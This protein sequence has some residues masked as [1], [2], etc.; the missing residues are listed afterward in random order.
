MTGRE[1]IL[2]AL[3]EQGTPSTPVVLCYPEIFMRDCWERVSS[4]PW[5]GMAS[6]D[7]EMALQAHRDLLDVTGE[8]RVRLWM[9]APRKDRQRYRIEGVDAKRARRIDTTTGAEEELRRPPPG[10]FLS[11]H[12]QHMLEKKE[13]TSQEQI[14]ELL[15]LPPVETPESLDADGRSDKPKAMLDEFYPEKMPWTQLP[16]P[17]DPLTHVFG[18]EGLMMAFALR[19]ELVAY[20]CRR[21]VECTT[22]RIQAWKA[23]GVELIWLEEGMSDQ[24]SPEQYRRIVLPHTRE[25]TAAIRAAGMKSI[26]Y[27]TGNPND[28]LDVLLAGGADALALEESRKNFTIDIAEIACRVDGRTALVGNMD[29]VKILEPGPPQAIRAEVARQLEA[30]RR[31]GGRF[32]MGLGGPITPATPIDHVR[33][34]AETVHELAP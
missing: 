14:D 12:D 8:D 34:I 7:I 26:Y 5:W 3:S 19:P 29:E 30:G 22:R 10:G 23:V 20:A 21:V 25:T 16:S 13:V 4:T 1:K 33:L 28:R 32:L 2:A 9:S 6:Q 18:F 31:N 15:P 11:Q 17:F 27:Y 24:I